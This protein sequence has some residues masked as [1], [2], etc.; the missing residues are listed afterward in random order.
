MENNNHKA[1]INAILAGVEVG[2]KAAIVPEGY[3]LESLEKFQEFPKTK[4]GKVRL[5]SVESMALYAKAHH[6][7]LSALFADSEA[8]KFLLVIDWHGSAI[9]DAAGWGDHSAS[10]QLHYT[11]EW[12]AWMAISGKPMGQATFAEFIEE[13]LPD[14]IEPTSADLLEAVLNVSGKRNIAFKSAKNLTNGDT[15]L[16]YEETTE[17]NGT[18]KGEASLPSKLAIRIPVF[19]GAENVTTFEIK[20]FLR[21]RIQEG[22][23]SFELKLHRPEKAKDE[24][25]KEVF[26]AMSEAMPKGLPIYE[27]S[28]EKWPR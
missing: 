23:L 5:D 17:A 28:I 16:I 3:T 14:I 25:L 18:T 9:N 24:A 10:Y 21:Y 27:G 26:K 1:L 13:N 22:R 15:Q 4:R 20:A 7:S 12:N 6:T 2:G 8:R 11:N 19:K